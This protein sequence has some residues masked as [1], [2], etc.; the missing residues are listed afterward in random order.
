MASW[1]VKGLKSRLFSYDN[2]ITDEKL[3]RA[4]TGLEVETFILKILYEYLDPGENFESTKYHEPGKDKEED[5][6]DV[7][8]S[9]SFLSP[10]SKPGPQS[11]LA[12]VDQLFLF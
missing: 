1:G 7:L 6:S 3:F 12:G 9:P 11:N 8:S 10:A 5:R 4:T 2:F